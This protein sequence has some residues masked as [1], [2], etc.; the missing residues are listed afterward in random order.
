MYDS[1]TSTHYQAQRWFIYKRKAFAEAS[2]AKL[3]ESTR[4]V[5][6]TLGYAIRASFQGSPYYIGIFDQI[7]PFNISISGKSIPIQYQSGFKDRTGYNS[8][9]DYCIFYIYGVLFVYCLLLFSTILCIISNEVHYWSIIRI[10]VAS[11][12]FQQSKLQIDQIFSPIVVHLTDALSRVET[13]SMWQNWNNGTDK[14]R[15][16]TCHWSAFSFFVAL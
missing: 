13:A 6:S 7:N 11:S 8:E 12:N 16:C 14:G 3:R 15:G 10:A 2:V 4:T 5:F 1:W 9:E